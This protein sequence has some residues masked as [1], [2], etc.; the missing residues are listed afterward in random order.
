MVATGT[1]ILVV[2]PV[3]SNYVRITAELSA[4]LEGSSD[5]AS[6]SFL[7]NF[8]SL[9]VLHAAGLQTNAGIEA[10]FPMRV[11]LLSLWRLAMLLGCSCK[12]AARAA[13]DHGLTK[14]EATEMEWIG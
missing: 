2:R 8:I 9:E 7:W 12:C 1:C 10:E 6:S 4:S 5:T 13:E 14:W 11:S 3:Q